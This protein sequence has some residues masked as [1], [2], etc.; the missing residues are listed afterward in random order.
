[1]L[2]METNYAEDVRAFNRSQ[3]FISEGEAGLPGPC[4]ESSKLILN[5]NL[6]EGQEELDSPLIDSIK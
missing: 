2:R 6:D 3:H 1:M 4:G 5:R